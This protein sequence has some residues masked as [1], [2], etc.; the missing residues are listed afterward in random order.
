MDEAYY[1]SLIDNLNLKSLPQRI[2]VKYAIA[3]N[4]TVLK[5]FPTRNHPIGEGR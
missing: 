3:V 2:E 4:R 5:T 1:N